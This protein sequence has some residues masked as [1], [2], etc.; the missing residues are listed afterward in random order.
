MPGDRAVVDD[1]AGALPLHDRCH[2]LH[3]QHPRAHQQ[4]HGGIEPATDTLAMLPV[5]AGPPASLNRQ[6]MRPNALS[7]WSIRR[8][9]SSWQVASAATNWA[10]WPMRPATAAPSTLRRPVQTTLAPSATNSSAVRAPI[11]LVAPVMSAT[12]PST[13]PMAL[14]LSALSPAAS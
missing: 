6:S 13:M 3:A 5:D 7:V 4:R 14:V 10:L 12:L 1:A 11:P 9:Q 2:V 8:F